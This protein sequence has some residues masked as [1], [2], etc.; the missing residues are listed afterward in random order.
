[1]VSVKWAILSA[2]ALFP[3]YWIVQLHS[4]GTNI[5]KTEQFLIYCWLP[6]DK[7]TCHANNEQIDGTIESYVWN[8]AKDDHTRC[9]VT[10]VLNQTKKKSLIWLDSN[11]SSNINKHKFNKQKWSQQEKLR[12]IN[13]TSEIKRKNDNREEKKLYKR[14]LLVDSDNDSFISS[15][16]I[17]RFFSCRQCSMRAEAYSSEC[18]SV[19]YIYIHARQL[20]YTRALF[21]YL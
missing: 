4:N 19:C 21:I 11:Q 8:M 17:V 15:S 18:V 10:Q 3:I 6:I 9:A 20:G 14:W 1:M 7:I 5:M 2:Y 12:R 13:K 16:S